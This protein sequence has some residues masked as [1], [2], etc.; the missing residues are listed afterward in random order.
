MGFHIVRRPPVTSVRVRLTLWYTLLLAGTVVGLGAALYFLLVRTLATQA[1]QDVSTTTLAVARAIGIERDNRTGQVDLRLP[2]LSVLGDADTFVQ[3]VDLRTGE[4]VARSAN[5]G[6][7]YLPPPTQPFPSATQ[8]GGSYR[9]YEEEGTR[10]RLSSRP[11]FDTDRRAVAMVQAAHSFTT[12]DRLLERLRLLLAIVGG[13]GLPTTALVG[14]V[15]A[16][17][18]LAP[19]DDMTRAAERIGHAR[20]F[21]QRLARTGPADELEHLARTINAML[22]ELEAAHSE[23]AE[24]NVRLADANARLERSLAVQRRFVADASHEMRTPLT[25][26]RANAD[27]LRWTISDSDSDQARA[28]A[29]LG[30]EV[31]RMSR[32]LEGLLNLARV[33]AGQRVTLQRTPLQPLLDEAF[34]HARLLAAGRQVEVV[35]TEAVDVWGN[36]DAL[37][38]LLLIVVDNAL[39]YTSDDGHIS[40]AL[41]RENGEARLS[42]SDTGIGISRQEVGHIFERFYR[43]DAARETEGSGLGLAIAQSIVQQHDG[44][45]E[46]KSEPGVGSTFTVILRTTEAADLRRE[47]AGHARAVRKPA[48]V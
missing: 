13:V 47:R 23:L 14:W 34:R 1:D 25:T 20:D 21:S 35:R 46:V 4:V 10:F 45:I 6:T 28:L 18:A 42:V 19:I 17:R 8:S 40:L 3:V 24:T 30:S 22:A 37:R 5:L 26:I 7:R 27:V 16:G 36:A 31:E 33:D 41:W 15:L 39:K 29:D 48:R 11:V 32:L 12:D 2:E 38:Q 43:A 44:R 9:T